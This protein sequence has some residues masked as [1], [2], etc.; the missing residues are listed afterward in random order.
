MY[1][2]IVNSAFIIIPMMIQ[3]GV[4]S[5]DYITA[6]MKNVLG[7]R[8]TRERDAIN[9][10]PRRRSPNAVHRLCTTR[11]LFTSINVRDVRK[12]KTVDERTDEKIS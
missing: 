8:R 6:G 10:N 11:F 2:N 3:I 5:A 4:K 7:M 12:E 9:L 1:W